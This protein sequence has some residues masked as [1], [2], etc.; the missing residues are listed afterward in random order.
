VFIATRLFGA[1]AVFAVLPMVLAVRGA[2]TPLEALAFAWCLAPLIAVWDISRHGAYDRAH[3]LSVLAVGGLIATVAGA[4]GGVHSFAAPWLV[5][6]PLASAVSASRRT[7]E[8]AIAVTVVIALGLWAAGDAGWLPAG[9]A[10]TPEL[11][12]LGILSAAFYVGAM[13]LGA[14]ALTR[15]SEQAKLTGE[16]RY[17][18]LARNMTDVITRHGKNGAVTFISPAA[19]QLFDV[20]IS[21]LLGHGLFD[22]VHVADRP[23]FLTA[24]ADA[25]SKGAESSVEYRIRRGPLASEDGAPLPPKFIWVETRCRGLK[26]DMSGDLATDQRRVVAVTRDIS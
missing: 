8:A 15:L 3:L 21:R 14:G 20:P 5:I 23:A 9:G 16:S 18:L 13:G 25:A 4:T 7:A 10:A 24:L 17:L 6:L 2:P 26:E 11:Y 12:L 19:A 1:L 22:R